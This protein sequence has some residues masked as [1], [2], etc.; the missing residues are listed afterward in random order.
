[1]SGPLL[2]RRTALLGL[3]GLLGGCTGLETIGNVISPGD[4]FDLSPKS[5]F[6]EDLPEVT[7]QIVV[8]EPIAASSVNTD[9]IAIKPTPLQVQYFANARWV[10]RAPRLVQTLMVESFE[11]TGRVAAVGRQAIGLVSDYTLITDL[12]EFT[13]DVFGSPNG[14]TRIV[15][16]INI[17]IVQEPQGQ[18]VASRSFGQELTSSSDAVADIVRVFDEALG[19]SMRDA[20]EWTVRE[21]ATLEAQRRF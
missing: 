21:I 9:R 17:K 14:D 16:Q 3:A 12:R 5:T 19:S 10:D 1:M 2:P 13:A 18:I 11:N 6:D 8:E 15:V 7:A 4:L 20:V